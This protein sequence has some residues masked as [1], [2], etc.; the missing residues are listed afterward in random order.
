VSA[1]V[2]DTRAPLVIAPAMETRMWENVVTQDNVALLKSRGAIIVEPGEGR[3]ASGASGK[4]RLGDLDD[5]L[6]TIRV[7]LGRN[8]D[9]AN[10]KIV[11]TAGGTQE[12]IDP[13]RVI[14][15]HSSGKM[16]FAIAQA[17]RDRGAHVTLIAGVTSL[18]FPRG[19]NI[20][21]A[22]TAQ[23]M[24]EA[25][26]REIVN[27]DAL[28][29]AAAVAD[30]RPA[31]ASAQKIKKGKEETITL[32]LVKNPDILKEVAEWRSKNPKSQS[33]K[34]QP[35]FVV[36]FA[37]ETQDLIANARAKLEAK[38]LDLMVANPVPSSFG[39]D[40]DQAMLI[41]RDGGITELP[42]L[43]KEELAEKILDTLH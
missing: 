38:N 14:A 39:S 21:S 12:P 9:L 26:M 10:R 5:I 34:S 7:T 3:L 20:V 11:V 43:P 15:N 16:G 37:A 29:M 23:A 35:L 24:H 13:V 25:V 32:E 8:G 28:I 36:G 42:P 17:A 19:M 41:E 40:V 22:V 33:A 4:G 31:Q 2:L 30:F 1:T 27:A 6:D 18:R